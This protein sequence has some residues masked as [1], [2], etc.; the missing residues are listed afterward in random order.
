VTPWWWRSG[1][2]CYHEKKS[3][4]SS[5]PSVP[6]YPCLARFLGHVQLK[7]LAPR[8]VEAYQFMV[9]HLARWSGRDPEEL[10][11]EQVREF[12][13]YLI[14]ERGYSP[15]SIRQA[16]ASLGA[17]YR[18]MLDREWKVFGTIKTKDPEKLPE[19][20]TREEV[21]LLLGSVRE[22]RFRICLQLIY[23]CGLRLGEGVRVKVS[24]LKRDKGDP[25]YRDKPGKLHVR[26]A[27]GGKDRMVPVSPAMLRDLGQ[28]WLTHQHP[29]YLFPGF[30]Y[31]WKNATRCDASSQVKAQAEI[32]RAA[33][34]PIGE[35]TLQNTFRKAVLESGLAGPAGSPNRKI[36]IHTLRHSYAT[37]MLEEG[38]HLR[39]ISSYLGHASIEQTMV[40]THLTKVTDD[41]TT[42]ALQRLSRDVRGLT[43]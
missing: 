25:A 39:V 32:M 21:K 9:R 3:K 8:T 28:W 12:F 13:L 16:R 27:K 40:Y 20:L 37:H 5:S 41:Q 22:P 7:G 6:Q 35:S 42:Q 19:V 29:Q 1:E 30:G 2:P 38:V 4:S 17:F 11:E 10:S 33:A 14:N 31:R 36:T 43:T 15:Q 18:E 23:E 24:D 34:E 26:H